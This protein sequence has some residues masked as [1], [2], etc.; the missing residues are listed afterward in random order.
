MLS[1]VEA[2]QY[3]PLKARLSVILRILL[4]VDGK[5]QPHYLSMTK[6]KNE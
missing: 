4:T 3:M 1:G 2:L 5:L 6:L